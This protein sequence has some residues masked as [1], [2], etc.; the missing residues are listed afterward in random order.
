MHARLAT[1]PLL[2]RRRKGFSPSTL[3]CKV[4]EPRA[5]PP[6]WR[7]HRH[8]SYC[9]QHDYGMDVATLKGRN[10]ERLCIL[11]SL[12][13]ITT[14]L[15]KSPL[16]VM[17]AVPPPCAFKVNLS[18]PLCICLAYCAKRRRGL[19][20]SVGGRWPTTFVCCVP[21]SIFWLGP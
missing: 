9:S 20:Q 11:L 18:R 4:Y 1:M 14:A 15:R 12:P 8:R 3:I 19:A 16:L 5:A 6:L 2:E 13:K 10:K 21:I 17:P 7:R